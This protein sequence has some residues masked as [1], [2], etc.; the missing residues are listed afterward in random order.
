MNPT[1]SG[2]L[3]V[4]REMGGQIRIE[5]KREQCGEVVAD[6]IA[7]AST[8]KACEC[9]PELIP[10]LIDEIPILAIAASAADGVSRI[11]GAEE[12]RV[13]ETDR[14]KALTTEL[15][16]LKARVNERPDGLIIEGPTRLKGG[17]VSSHG[18]HRMA[19]ALTVAAG[20]SEG[21]VSIDDYDCVS[22]SYPN[23]LKDWQ[24]VTQ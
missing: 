3:E 6:I 8:L 7:E 13:K 12:L 15:S 10:S 16:K 21:P 4:L 18:D 14:L 19:M 23:F 22:V 9:P 2:L 5:N 20:I 17:T 1:R 24:Q 11:W